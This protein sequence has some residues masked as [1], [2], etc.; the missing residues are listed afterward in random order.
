MQTGDLVV[1]R[2]ARGYH[3]TEGKTYEVVR[4]E[5]RVADLNFTWPAYVHVVDDYGKLV[6]CHASRFEAVV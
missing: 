3:F 6:V 2:A 1:C 4:Y 5:P